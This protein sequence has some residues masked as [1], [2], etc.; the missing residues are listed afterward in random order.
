M[1]NSE[2]FLT[3][4]SNGTG[5]YNFSGQRDRSFFIV[6]GQR[7]NGTSSKSC[8][9]TG[10]AG[11]AKIWDGMG[12]NSQYPG[13]DAG[14]DN[15]Y[16]FPMISCF[17]TSFSALSRVLSWILAVPA[18]PVPGFRCPGRPVPWQDFELVLLSLCP[19][20]MKEFL[21]ICPKK[22]HCPVLFKTLVH[23]PKIPLF[24]FLVV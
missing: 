10:R 2:W 19:G 5:Q 16:F 22:L 8:Q 4:V 1:G 13:R 7:D 3:R 11:T 6:P 24:R 12:R 14:R 18:R 15:H 20:T 23:R 17:R 9:G 21:S